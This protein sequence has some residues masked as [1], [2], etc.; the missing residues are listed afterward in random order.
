MSTVVAE[1]H[2]KQAAMLLGGLAK[3]QVGGGTDTAIATDPGLS[4]MMY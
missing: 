4:G 2:C 3:H 1:A